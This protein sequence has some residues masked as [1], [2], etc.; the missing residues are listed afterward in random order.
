MLLA[1]CGSQ[2]APS[3][4]TPRPAPKPDLIARLDNLPQGVARVQQQSGSRR[5]LAHID[6]SGLVPN[7]AHA[8][9]LRRGACLQR[10]GPLLASFADATSN[11]T[12]GMSADV[13][14][15]AA[16]LAGGEYL[17]LHLVGAAQLAAGAVPI[18]CADISTTAPTSGSRMT[19][20]PGFKPFGTISLTYTASN[21]SGSLG[22]S[23]QGLVGG[24]QHAVQIL[25]GTCSALGPV[26]HAAGDVTG[27][28]GGTVK[29]RLT[30]AGLGGPPPVSGWILVVRSGATAAIGTATQPTAQAQPILCG[31]LAKPA[32]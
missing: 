2:G 14:G 30:V 20:P 3:G 8:V 17:E 25:S 22:V 4:G 21:R 19:A 16:P 23:L 15:P 11:A 7:T 5:L 31:A 10:G 27:D 12:G 24:S 26:L 18:A 6:L 29:A 28:S 32:P 1:A 9:Q 13:A